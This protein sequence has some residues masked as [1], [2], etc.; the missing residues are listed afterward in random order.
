MEPAV[1]Y[2]GIL[3]CSVD[4]ENPLAEGT[5]QFVQDKLMILDGISI[6]KYKPE[7]NQALLYKALLKKNTG[8]ISI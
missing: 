3:F 4:S 8:E 7:F 2:S 5:I 6:Y 1:G